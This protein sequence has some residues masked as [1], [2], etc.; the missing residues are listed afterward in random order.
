MPPPAPADA[1]SFGEACW[2]ALVL[3]VVQGLTEFLPISSTAHL[4]AVPVLLGWG[5]PGV[6]FT[7]VIQLGS[8]AAVLAYFRRDLADVLRGITRAFRLGRWSDPSA[9]LGVAIAL[10]TLPIVFAGLVLKLWVPGYETSVVRSMGSIAV[11][12]IVMALLLALAELMGRRRRALRDVLPRDGLLVGAAQALSLLPGVSRSG[13]TLT[14][15]LFDGWQRPAAA[16]FSFLLGIPAITLAG[17]VELKGAL[18]TPNN[19][20][21]IPTL[22]GIVS[23]AVVSWLA[24]AWLLRFLQRHSTWL[25]VGYRLLFGVVILLWLGVSGGAAAP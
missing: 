7:A 15:S 6:A 22:V 9:R 19:G 2:H 4:K 3:G 13:S 14:A 17:L 25:F 12:S 11:V 10:G 24:I 1:L 5:D 16:R 20:G 23:A 21:V 18:S 8:I